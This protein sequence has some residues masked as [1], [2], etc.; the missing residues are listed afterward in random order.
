MSTALTL[1]AACYT[2]VRQEVRASVDDGKNSV[3]HRITRTAGQGG[4]VAYYVAVESPPGVARHFAVSG[5][6][7]AGPVVVVG[8][9]EDGRRYEEVVAHPRSF[10]EFASDDWIHRFFEARC[11][12]ALAVDR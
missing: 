4:D 10:G 8:Q 5:N 1:P 6:I 11:G 3:V 9:G 2:V 7:F 12:G